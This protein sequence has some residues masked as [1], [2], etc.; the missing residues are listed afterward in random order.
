M[1][2]SAGVFLELERLNLDELEILKVGECGDSK[3]P[4]SHPG[5]L[6]P[7]QH[8]YVYESS[9]PPVLNIHSAHR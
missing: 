1:L 3:V 2:S 5:P 8:E 4:Q 9:A 7:R 6:R